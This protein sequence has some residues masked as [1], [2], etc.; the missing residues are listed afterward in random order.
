MRGFKVL[1]GTGA[2]QAFPA[3]RLLRALIDARVGVEVMDTRAACRTFC[4]LAPTLHARGISTSMRWACAC[5]IIPAMALRSCTARI[6]ATI[7]CS[8]SPNPRVQGSITRAGM[9]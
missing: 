5:P 1:L 4:F 9:W 6:R 3:P 8:R 2:K 7:T